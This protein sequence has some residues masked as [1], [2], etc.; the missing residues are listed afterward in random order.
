LRRY[1][2][3]FDTSKTLGGIGAILMLVGIIPVVSFYG[4]LEFVGAILILVALKGLSDY[5]QS[6]GIFKNALYGIIVGIVGA[7]VALVVAIAAILPNITPLLMEIYPGWDG[8]WASLQ[9]MDPNTNAFNPTTFDPSSLISLAMGVIGILVI[10]WIVA[11]IGTFFIRRSLKQ[12]NEKSGVGLFGTAGLML[13]IGA[14]LIIAFGFGAIL[15]WI[16]ILLLAIAF[17]QL[18]PTTSMDQPGAY[19]PPPPPPTP[20]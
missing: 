14:V 12:I 16:G 17:F 18:K 1:Q 10:V 5:Y 13:L 20:I 19:A 2:L 7:I 9:N 6:V 3:N 8:N 11:I 15:M 4:I